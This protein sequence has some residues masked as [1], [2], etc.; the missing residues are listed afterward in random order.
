MANRYLLAHT[1][2][3]EQILSK[4]SIN[5]TTGLT[6]KEALNRQSQYGPNELPKAKGRTLFQKLIDQLS[7]F[8]ILILVAAAFISCLMGEYIDA[9]LII[10]I[11]VINAIFG[12]I[13]ENKA[14]K[15]LEALKDMSAPK[16]TALRDGKRQELDARR[17]VPGDIVYL[18]AGGNV[19][20]DLRLIE[21]TNLEIQEATL[22]GESVPSGKDA[23]KAY[24]SD[25][26]LGDRKNMAYMNTIITYGRGTGLV[27]STGMQTEI[28]KIAHA[29]GSLDTS[30]T[31]LQ[32]K[33]NDLSKKIGIA[34]LLICGIVFLTGFLKHLDSPIHLFLTAISLAVAAIPEG[35]P[36]IVTIILALGMTK[37]SKQNAVI[38]RLLAVET[39]GTT[40]VICSDKTGTLTENQMTVVK[41]VLPSGKFNVHGTGYD[42]IGRF[43]LISGKKTGLSET[44]TAGLLCSDAILTKKG[45]RN[46]IIGD[47]TEGAIVVAAAKYNL[48][49]KDLE[50]LYPRLLELPFES[51]RKKMSTLHKYKSQYKLFTKGAPDEI[52][53]KSTN[54][55]LDGKI[56]ALT[57]LLRKNITKEIEGMSDQALRILGFAYKDYTK[58][59]R[60]LTEADETA[61]T[62]LGLVG[63][64]DPPRQETKDAISRARLAGITPKMVTGDYSRTALAVGKLIGLT[65]QNDQI[66]TG[67]D[68]DKL[69]DDKLTELVEKVDIYARVSPE[70]K[71]KIVDALKKNGHVVAMTGDGVNDAMALKRAD[72]GISMGIS[73]TDV[74]KQTSDMVLV[75]DNFA[76]IVKAIREGRIIYSNIKKVIF[77]LLSCNLA[78]VL[79]IIISMLFGLPIPLNPV[80]L[81]WINLVTDALPAIALGTERGE[82][83]IMQH[84]PRNTQ[85]PLLSKSTW[86]MVLFHASILAFA[87]LFAFLIGLSTFNSLAIGRTMAFLTIICGELFRAFSCRSEY[88]IILKTGLF[89]NRLMIY[90]VIASVLLIVPLFAFPALSAAFALA[91]LTNVQWCIVFLLSV[92]P[93]I[94]GE[95]TKLTTPAPKKFSKKAPVKIN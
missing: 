65:T 1:L 11:V 47:P 45:N 94:F 48:L 86:I 83:N 23:D 58:L 73:G 3:K 52:L 49:K 88:T 89:S 38:R 67:E 50:S 79:V 90:A 25:T 59:P 31:P 19:P 37:M 39:L 57:P 13:Q 66:L 24:K 6:E 55:V 20:A 69:S 29:I 84:K 33:L 75:D 26:A 54:V 2:T 27:V 16:A 64:I 91:S 18:E 36:A 80:H 81:L 41:V 7:D 42:P 74:A 10:S 61:L 62:F 68:I 92:I 60:K 78:E 21:T 76:S 93:L 14:D 15:A 34:V 77:F 35:L 17:L 8:L 28:G 43:K 9:L 53:K 70:H 4:L 82:Q 32:I 30:P 12:L 44:L 5:Q 63:M 56:V 72:I 51:S 40:T 46:T 87:T 85:E 71:V 22:T 95:L